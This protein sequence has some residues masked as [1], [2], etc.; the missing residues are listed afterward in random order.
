MAGTAVRSTPATGTLLSS[1]HRL[2]RRAALNVPGHER[3][4]RGNRAEAGASAQMP[5]WLT[6]AA[7]PDLGCDRATFRATKVPAGEKFTRIN[8]TTAD[9]IDPPGVAG[10][11]TPSGGRYTARGQIRYSP[12]PIPTMGDD[13]SRGHLHDAGVRR[14]FVPDAFST[15][16]SRGSIRSATLTRSSNAGATT[17]TKIRPARSIAGFDTTVGAANRYLDLVSGTPSQPPASRARCEAHQYEASIAVRPRRQLQRAWLCRNACLHHRR[18]RR[19]AALSRC[20]QRSDVDAYSAR[21]LASD[22]YRQPASGMG[23][24]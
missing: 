21:C 12:R 24:K 17:P 10:I 14:E 16:S 1:L 13:G 19:H 20:L 6:C 18:R 9:F 3:S 7:M 15:T 23:V 5:F 4:P 2:E 11:G 8:H 22:G